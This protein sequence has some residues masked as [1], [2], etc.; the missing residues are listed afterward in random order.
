MNIETVVTL[1][2]DL[3]AALDRRAPSPLDRDELV[4]GIH[5]EVDLAAS[6]RAPEMQ[7]PLGTVSPGRPRP[8]VL[9]HEPLEG[10]PVGFVASV[11]GTAGP[12]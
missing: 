12:E 6:A 7:A 5:H 9:E 1:P 2:E 8:Q 11:Q 3:K 4:L 10:R